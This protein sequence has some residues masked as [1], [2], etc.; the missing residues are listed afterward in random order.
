MKILQIINSHALEDGGAQRL[1]LQFHRAF[2]ERG[3]DAHLLSLMRSPTDEPNTYSLGFE[4]PYR[5]AVV[6][7][8]RAFLNEARWRDVDLVHVHLFPAQL[9]APLV[10]AS[11]RRRVP[12][13]TTEHNTHNRRRE[14][15]SWRRLDGAV[16]RRYA[17]I[18]C[19]SE[20]THQAMARWLPETAPRLR[21]IHNGIALPPLDAPQRAST[22]TPIILSLG[23]ISAQKNYA[24]AIRA[25]ALLPRDSCELHIAG[26]SDSAALL[27]Q[28]RELARALGVENEVRFL[29]FRADAARLLENADL[30]LSTSRWEGFGLA[31]AEAM[32]AGLP[33]VAADV[34]GVREVVGGEDENTPRAG[35]LAPPDAPQKFADALATLLGSEALRRE[36]GINARRRAQRFDIENTIAS[37]LHLYQEVLVEGAASTRSAV[38]DV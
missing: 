18:A 27:R 1:A 4:S 35:F 31:V 10:L 3:H 34:D 38:R 25:L 23:R 15:A 2:R 33:V 13:I 37:Y 17:R 32:A 9:F 20:G 24:T 14:S 21:T 36:I 19:I 28:L 30:Y 6:P 12:L 11:L 8:L 29:G 26:K 22:R 7:R 5:S 16:Y